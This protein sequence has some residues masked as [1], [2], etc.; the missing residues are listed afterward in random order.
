MALST[1]PTSSVSTDAPYRDDGKMDVLSKVIDYK[2]SK[3]KKQK[4]NIT[5]YI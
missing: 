4:A 2:P 1:D 5:A 3:F